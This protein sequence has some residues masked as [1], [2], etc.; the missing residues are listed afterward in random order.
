MI[1]R[2]DELINRPFLVPEC[3][4]LVFLGPREFVKQDFVLNSQEALKEL[5]QVIRFG[6]TGLRSQVIQPLLNLWIKPN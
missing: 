4:A 5:A 6:P 3:S 1:D 2:F